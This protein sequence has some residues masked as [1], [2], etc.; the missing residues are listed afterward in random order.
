VPVR[1]NA[2]GDIAGSYYTTSRHLRGFIRTAGGTLIPVDAHDPA[3]GETRIADFNANGTVIGQFR[4]IG[5]N[6]W[7]A[8]VRSS[9]GKITKF[10]IGDS[11]RAYPASINKHNTIAGSFV[12]TQGTHGFIRTAQGAVTIVDFPDAKTGIVTINDNGDCVGVYKTGPTQ[13]GFIRKADGT[14]IHF[15]APNTQEM[16]TW[17]FGMNNHGNVAGWYWDAN[18][19]THAYLLRQ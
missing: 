3:T 5:K 18:T 7:R 10:T 13:H 14:I 17:V 1:I 12:D 8:F 2:A 11:K 19:A 6:H 15:D 9:S 4:Q 16:G